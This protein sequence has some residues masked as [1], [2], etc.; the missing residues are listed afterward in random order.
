MNEKLHADYYANLLPQ[1]KHSTKGLGKTAPGSGEFID[2]GKV[3]VP[4]GKGEPTNIPSV[5]FI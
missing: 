2:G 1:G 3:Y 5:I 4:K